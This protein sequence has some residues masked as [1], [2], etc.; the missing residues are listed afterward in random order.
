MKMLMFLNLDSFNLD[1]KEIQ[2]HSTARGSLM[3]KRIVMVI[4]SSFAEYIK[5]ASYKLKDAS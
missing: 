5:S 2:E 4:N 1:N 3:P